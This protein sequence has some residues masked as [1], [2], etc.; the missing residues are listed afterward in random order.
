MVKFYRG[1]VSAFV[2]TIDFF[3]LSSFL[4]FL[5]RQYL[6]DQHLPYTVTTV[7]KDVLFFFFKL[8]ILFFFLI[9]G[10]CTMSYTMVGNPGQQNLL[11]LVPLK[12]KVKDGSFQLGKDGSFQMSRVNCLYASYAL[13]NEHYL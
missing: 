11:L 7:Q 9:G 13:K 2:Q 10:M 12:T 1:G 5:L 4:S 8:P 6:A 3:F